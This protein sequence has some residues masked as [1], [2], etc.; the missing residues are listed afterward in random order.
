MAMK[1][2]LTHE[3]EQAVRQGRPVE[4]IDP[5]SNRAF[6]VV[7][8]ELYESVRPL[9]EGGQDGGPSSSPP[10]AL[11]P[12]V[13]PEVKPLRQRVRDLPLPPE[14]A[15]EAKRYC[16]YLGTSRAKDIREMEEQ[17]KLQHYYGG[18]WIAYLRTDEGPVVVAA[19][20]SLSDPVFDQQLSFLTP[21]ERRRR[22]ID[23]PIK[24]FDE[25]SIL[26]ALSDE[27]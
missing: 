3:Q 2:E 20:K 14:V 12:A 1:I 24:L 6:V 5:A 18:K 8:R 4:V 17:M 16:K 27:S 21:E 25:E 22:I 26:D 11:A 10:P 23:S 7:T 13:T 19:A 9:L 15:A